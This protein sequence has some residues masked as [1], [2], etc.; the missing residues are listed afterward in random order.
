MD[1]V[2]AYYHKYSDAMDIWFGNPEDEYV[3]SMRR[4]YP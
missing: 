1:K 4:H 3:R 2:V